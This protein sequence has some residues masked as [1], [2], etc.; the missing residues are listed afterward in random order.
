MFPSSQF[1]KLMVG[2]I[3]MLKVE[4]MLMLDRLIS[5]NIPIEKKFRNLYCDSFGEF[6]DSLVAQLEI[7]VESIIVLIN[8]EHGL[9]SKIKNF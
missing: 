5:E 2:L 6:K 7:F 8:P 3:V 9:N 1:K 4:R